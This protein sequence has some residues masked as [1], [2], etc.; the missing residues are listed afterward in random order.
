MIRTLLIKALSAFKD[1]VYLLNSS[2]I[3]VVHQNNFI[4]VR[5]NLLKKDLLLALIYN[6]F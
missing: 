4:L 3:D 6:K 5:I 1:R 2:L